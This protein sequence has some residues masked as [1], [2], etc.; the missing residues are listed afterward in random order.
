MQLL[1][2]KVADLR[3]APFTKEMSFDSYS[4]SQISLSVVKQPK[5]HQ[6]VH[7]YKPPEALNE[8]DRLIFVEGDGITPLGALQKVQHNVKENSNYAQ[9]SWSR[10]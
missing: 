8:I 10:H 1:C 3:E 2:N 4:L 5:C 7:F 9:R 6:G